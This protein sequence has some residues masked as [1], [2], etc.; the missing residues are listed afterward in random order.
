MSDSAFGDE[1]DTGAEGPGRGLLA[2]ALG[3]AVLAGI[4]VVGLAWAKWL[5][6]AGKVH[7]LA[8]TRIWNGSSVLGSGGT[9]PSL[10]AAVEFARVYGK[11]IWK[12]LVVSLLIAA[13]LDALVPKRWVVRLLARRSRWGQAAAG[14]LVSLPSMMCTCCTAPVTVSLRRAG[15]PLPAAVAYWLGNPLLNPAVLAFL[16]LVAPWQWAVTRLTVGLVLVV[17]AG[18]LLGGFPRSTGRPT[19]E[20][21]LPQDAEVP[22]R[23]AQLPGRFLR[24]LV[25]LSA[26]L[27]PEYALVV[28]LIGGF[29]GWLSQFA[30]LQ[31]HLGLLAVLVAVLAGT[32]LVIPTG[33]EIPVLLTL[34]AMGA[35]SGMVGALLV[36]LPAL[37]LPSMVMVGRALSPRLT[38]LLAGTVAA[39][40][41]L[42][43]VGLSAIT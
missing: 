33:G 37:S 4:T 6:Y 29:S 3:V 11:A 14:G 10:H 34:A 2:A 8:G 9:S 38:A 41:V 15:V 30:S 1:R 21:L 18:A 23:P 16:F 24:S 5:P 7:T 19:P 35:G 32:L 17:G 39:G 26:V 12:A 43:A 40:G 31:A 28:L 27:V 36:T 25:R 42:A 20:E 22:P 13:G